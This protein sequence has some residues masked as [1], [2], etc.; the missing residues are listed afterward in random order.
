M[1]KNYKKIFAIGIS[2]IAF[3]ACTGDL[4]T[5]PLT[6]TTLLSEK[7][8][9]EADSYE[10]YTAK[11]YAAFATPGDGPGNS[12]ANDIVGADQGEATFTRSYW[13][14]E[15]LTTDESMVAWSDE[16]L[17]G[18]QFDQWTS[19]NRFLMLN[20][21]RMCLIN[22][23]CNEFLK[24]T[25]DDK[26]N[27]RGHGDKLEAVH[28]NRAEVR[29]LRALSYYVLMNFYANVPFVDEN[30]GIGAY[31]PEQKGR[32]FLFPWIEQE[33]K[34]I[35][36]ELPQKSASTYGMVNKY[37]VDMI[38]AN[39]YMNAEVFGQGNH[40]ADAVTYL[41]D[42]I[43]NGGYILEP[44][45]KY[46]FQADNDKS[47]E[48]IFPIVYDG[49]Y[50]QSYGGTT[51]L[52]AGAYGDDMAPGDNFGLPQFW[53]GIRAP[54]ELSS[55]FKPGD[56]RALFWTDDRTQ[57]IKE[58][59]NFKQGYSVVKY[60]NLTRDG[61]K[62]IDQTFPDTDFPFYRLADA[63]LLYVEAALRGAGDASKAVTYYNRVQ[64]RAFGN[65]SQNI[66]SLTEITLDNLLDERARELYWEGHRRTDLIRFNRFID[67]KNWSWKNGTQSGSMKLDSKYLL[68][69]L[70][71]T[72]LSSNSNLKQ[73][74][75][76]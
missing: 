7:A 26:V 14:L 28:K 37:V 57:E 46:N 35:I 15:E 64:E 16:G 69:P 44:T 48:I 43:E 10:A 12:S 58:W 60:T 73:N 13:N 31:L 4:D 55:L 20:Y 34:E 59:G 45:Y 23:F 72:D 70:P 54:Y 40:Y 29:A 68:F 24:Q 62:G 36:N 61:G 41:S 49:V 52:C 8:W 19:T 47:P 75:G 2:M 25:T 18:L 51:Y 32:D 9:A 30:S 56:S 67:N 66:S 74:P 42:I 38:L 5:E 11:V 27:G 63:Y 17:N 22:A 65:T 71:S 53:S 6:P 3:T 50:A 39:L 1:K 21:D 33:L 76:Y